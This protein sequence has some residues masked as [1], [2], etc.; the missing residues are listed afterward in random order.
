MVV[1]LIWVSLVVAQFPC[2]LV[3]DF[4]CFFFCLFSD[5]VV[6][7]VSYGL[8]FSTMVV[9]YGS[10][11]QGLVGLIFDVSIVVV[12]AKFRWLGRVL[13]VGS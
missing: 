8:V 3:V 5:L 11:F 1:A 7:V 13:L 9:G 4:F 6:V 12:M 10:V 2:L